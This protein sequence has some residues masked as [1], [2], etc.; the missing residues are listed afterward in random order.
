MSKLRND[1]ARISP[2]SAVYAAGATAL[3]GGLLAL[4][5]TTPSH[6][7]PP[8]PST[9]DTSGFMSAQCILT[10]HSQ[11]GDAL[12]RCE[13]KTEAQGGSKPSQ[14]VFAS[15][16]VFKA[17]FESSVAVTRCEDR[18]REPGGPAGPTEK[19]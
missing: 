12:R 3:L 11:L 10:A 6:A 9:I 4:G 17:Y 5:H 19:M 1:H 7:A 13:R 14:R 16:C 2:L 15:M 18:G 8:P